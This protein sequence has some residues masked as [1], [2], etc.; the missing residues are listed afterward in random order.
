MDQIQKLSD[1]GFVCFTFS[2]I[3]MEVKENGE[4]KKTPHNMPKHSDINSSN[5]K[6]Y[7]KASDKACAILTGKKSNITV[8]DFDDKA[9]YESMVSKFP[10]L[11]KYRTVKTNKGYHIYCQYDPNIKTTVN[12]LMSYPKVDIRNDGGLVFCSPTTYKLVDGSIAKYEDIGGE[13]LPIPEIIMSDIKADNFLNRVKQVTQ[14]KVEPLKKPKD[15]SKIEN[16]N[17]EYIDNCIEKGYL[18]FKALSESYDDW[19]DVGFIFKHT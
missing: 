9:C 12:A 2:S 4:A 16:G 5:F 8:I 7:C 11:L 18:D 19:R 14:L 17:L 13:I 3:S 10:D 15:V 6:N 1:D